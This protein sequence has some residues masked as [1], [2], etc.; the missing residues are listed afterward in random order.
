MN[1][2]KIMESLK[3]NILVINENYYVSKTYEERLEILKIVYTEEDE[4][5]FNSISNLFY[6]HKSRGSVEIVLPGSGL[7]QSL[8]FDD[9]FMLDKTTGF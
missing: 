1:I 9:Y 6:Y 5:Q 7:E 4:W 2:E 8:N 3:K